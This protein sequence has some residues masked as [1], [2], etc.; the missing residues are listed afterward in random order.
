MAVYFF[1]AFCASSSLLAPVI[2]ILPEAKISAVVRG[3]RI[4][5]ITAWNLLGLYSALRAVCVILSR[6]TLHPR[7]TVAI[8]FCIR[9][10]IVWIGAA[11]EDGAAALLLLGAV[12]MLPL[13]ELLL[14]LLDML[15]MLCV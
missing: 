7:L 4:R 15:Q 5:M 3:S 6:S 1:P 11:E 14:E 9:S 10:W 2:I 8:R 12:G 13:L